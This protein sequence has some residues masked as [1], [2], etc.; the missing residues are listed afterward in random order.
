MGSINKKTAFNALLV[1]LLAGAA[2]GSAEIRWVSPNDML[3]NTPHSD[4]PQDEN[5]SAEQLVD[6]PRIYNT[7]NASEQVVCILQAMQQSTEGQENIFTLQDYLQQNG[8]TDA[9]WVTLQNYLPQ[10]V[11]AVE[12]TYDDL[13][14]LLSGIVYLAESQTDNR[15]LWE[16][17]DA[18]DRI[19]YIRRS[20]HENYGSLLYNNFRLGA[21][22][23]VSVLPSSSVPVPGFE[24][25]PFPKAYRQT[26]EYQRDMRLLRAFHE[27]CH[28][29]ET[30]IEEAGMNQAEA[31]RDICA[32]AVMAY[33][34]GGV[35]TA[36]RDY[37]EWR[38]FDNFNVAVAVGGVPISHAT[39][40]IIEEYLNDLEARGDFSARILDVAFDTPQLLQRPYFTRHTEAEILGSNIEA[41]RLVRST[42]QRPNRAGQY[43][44]LQ[45]AQNV[46]NMNADDTHEYE[47]A[48]TQSVIEDYIEGLLEWCPE[49]AQILR[50]APT[51]TVPTPP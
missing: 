19:G 28:Y 36:M 13:I 32:L 23:G 37:V 31:L 34:R 27:T 49:Y 3:A 18:G 7:P 10:D 30:G 26:D 21:A 42:L 43:T 40:P 39:G 6:N 1:S 22:G 24:T 45:A 14:P 44:R 5:L 8:V 51:T 38:K 47:Y 9:Q 16:P 46:L 41:V 12:S 35:T 2:V 11:L 15:A 20:M 50:R 48:E 25:L 33:L 29:N 17:Q 4:C